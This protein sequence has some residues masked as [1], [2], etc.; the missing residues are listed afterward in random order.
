MGDIG[1]IPGLGR[2]PV[3]GNS[4]PLQYSDLGN[5]MDYI[6]HGVAKGCKEPETFTF[7]DMLIFPHLGL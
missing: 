5:S 6:V 7:F 3:E 2:F 1:L 4:Y